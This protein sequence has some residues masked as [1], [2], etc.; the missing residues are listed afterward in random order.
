MYVVER[1]DASPFTANQRR[2]YAA[3]LGKRSYAARVRRLGLRRLQE[4]ARINGKQ[5]GRPPSRSK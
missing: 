4:I 3:W 1:V 2:A 5:G